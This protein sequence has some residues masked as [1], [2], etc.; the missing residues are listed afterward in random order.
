MG[1]S[2]LPSQ[3]PGHSEFFPSSPQL[4]FYKI[5]KFDMIREELRPKVGDFTKGKAIGVFVLPAKDWG[6]TSVVHSFQS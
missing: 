2:V 3:R 6:L 5:R 4:L 1:I